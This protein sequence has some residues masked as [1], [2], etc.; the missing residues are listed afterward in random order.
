M[1]RAI[2]I[3]LLLGAMAF[4]A[5]PRW[6]GSNEWYYKGQAL[7]ILIW[8]VAARIKRVDK[9]VSYLW[10]WTILLAINNTIDEFWGDPEVLGNLEITISILSTLWTLYKIIKCRNTTRY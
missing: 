7:S 2:Q 9:I 5:I 4:N 10:D 6:V 1:Y 3:T 8:V